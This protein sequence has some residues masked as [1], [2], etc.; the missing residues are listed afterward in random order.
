M[1]VNRGN[2][3]EHLYLTRRSAKLQRHSSALARSPACRGQRQQWK[4]DSS[5]LVRLAS[6]FAV[7]QV[8]GQCLNTL[9]YAVLIVDSKSDVAATV[10]NAWIYVFDLQY[11]T[12]STFLMMLR[13]G[14]QPHGFLAERIFSKSFRSYCLKCTGWSTTSVSSVSVTSSS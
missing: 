9:Y 5:S 3:L 13:R 2:S 1:Y 6:V 7:I 11:L 12:S 4:I 8:I 14:L 10:Q